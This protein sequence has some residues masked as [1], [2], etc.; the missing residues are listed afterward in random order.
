MSLQPDTQRKKGYKSTGRRRR[1]DSLFMVRKNKRRRDSL[2]KRR[3]LVRQDISSPLI[4][5]SPL[6]TIYIPDHDVLVSQC[7]LTATNHSDNDTDIIVRQPYVLHNFN[8]S[9]IEQT[10]WALVNIAGNSP[11]ASDHVLN[12]GAL[13][14]LL[15]LLWNPSTT[16]KS[17]WNIAKWAF[18]NLCH[19]KS[20]PTL[21][22]QHALLLS[23]SYIRPA[24][25]AIRELLLMHDEEV[26]LYACQILSCITQ[27]VQVKWSKPSLKQMFR[28]T[29]ILGDIASGD[30]AQTQ[31]LMNSGALHCLKFL[32][33]Q[34]DKIILELKL[35]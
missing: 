26:V 29:T 5:D 6:S 7:C 4:D 19:G 2:S 12:D 25:P 16:K 28:V 3:K 13:L 34:S 31:V 1:E 32:L 35:V 17:I 24:L 10:L 11:S 21:Y 8:V 30:D 20:L 33:T 23:F 14:P 15:C 22:E 27:M 9:C 18:L